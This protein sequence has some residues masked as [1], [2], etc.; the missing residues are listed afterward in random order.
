MRFLTGLKQVCKQLE[1]SVFATA[2]QT[3]IL[4]FPINPIAVQAWC[5]S[6][7]N[8]YFYLYLLLYGVQTTLSFW[9]FCTKQDFP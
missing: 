3:G 6:F 4:E 5:V 8:L 9:C 7:G 2:F 1:R